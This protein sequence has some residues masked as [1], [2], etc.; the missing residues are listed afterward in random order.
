MQT[1]VHLP[2]RSQA[3]LNLERSK[4]VATAAAVTFAK[5]CMPLIN[6]SFNSWL[7]QTESFKQRHKWYTNERKY[8]VITSFSLEKGLICSKYNLRNINLTALLMSF[9]F[10]VLAD[11]FVNCTLEM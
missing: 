10:L 3:V 4:A 5:L 2:P 6:L 7:L 9:H 1:F 11:S 8:L